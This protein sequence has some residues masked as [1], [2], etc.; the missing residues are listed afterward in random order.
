MNIKEFFY[1][2]KKKLITAAIVF[3]ILFFWPIPVTPLNVPLGILFLIGI[4]TAPFVIF[5]PNASM[6]DRVSTIILFFLALIVIEII[7][8]FIC[9]F[10]H[11]LENFGTRKTKAI[12]ITIFLIV[13][14]ATAH[15]F[16]SFDYEKINNY[17]SD[18]ESSFRKISF[19]CEIP[20]CETN[21]Y[22]ACKRQCLPKLN[23]LI[24]VTVS[25][26]ENGLFYCKCQGK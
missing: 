6:G 8:L 19:P 22:E 20:L 10:W 26:V 11:I 2:T 15:F 21:P 9:A 23:T 12:G 24:N 14:I 3:T 7:Y 1:P 25:E 4:I 17:L 5:S 13:I 18:I 16:I